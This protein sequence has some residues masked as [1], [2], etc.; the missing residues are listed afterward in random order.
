MMND[1]LVAIPSREEMV[2]LFPL[3]AKNEMPVPYMVSGESFDIAVC[4]VGLL[5]FSVNLAYVLSKCKYKRVFQVGIC[6]AYPD[7]G[8]KVGDVVRVESDRVG[9]IGVQDSSGFFLPWSRIGGGDTTIYCD[10][11]GNLSGALNSIRAVTGLSVNCCTGTKELS[12]DRVSLF[13]VDVES[14]EGAAALAVCKRF[15]I[16]CYEFRSVSNI[17]SDRDPSTW[18]INEALMALRL[19]VLDH[20]SE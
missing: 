4:G 6:G 7:R 3:Y 17:V 19:Q 8:L 11:A 18:K 16:P 5:E 1:I 20:I 14:M 10:A 9:D 13:D 2:K 12:R 15:G